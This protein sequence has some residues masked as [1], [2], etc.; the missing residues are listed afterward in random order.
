M[1]KIKVYFW[2][3][4]QNHLNI[5]L[6]NDYFILVHFIDYIDLIKLKTKKVIIG[7]IFKEVYLKNLFMRK[8][9]F[10]DLNFIFRK[11]VYDVLVRFDLK[12]EIFIIF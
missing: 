8:G 1:N 9:V 3:N 10:K 2:I 7:I 12:I 11:V 5:L 6:D 4:F